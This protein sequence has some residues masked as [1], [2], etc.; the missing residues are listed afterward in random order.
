MTSVPQH[1][2]LNPKRRSTFIEG[3][4]ERGC[5]VCA[6]QTDLYYPRQLSM[7]MIVLTCSKTKYTGRVFSSKA[8]VQSRVNTK[9]VSGVFFRNTETIFPWTTLVWSTTIVLQ[10]G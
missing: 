8:G 10:L 2:D 1:G 4:T 7:H 6:D 3:G 9:R 5:G